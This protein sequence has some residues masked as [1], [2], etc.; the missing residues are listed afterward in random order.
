LDLRLSYTECS[1]LDNRRNKGVK[2]LPVFGISIGYICSN[3]RSAKP[4]SFRLQPEFSEPVV[5]RALPREIRSKLL[6]M[7]LLFRSILN[8]QFTPLQ[9]V[10]WSLRIA[11][12]LFLF[13]TCPHPTFLFKCRKGYYQNSFVPF[14]LNFFVV[15]GWLLQSKERKIRQNSCFR[16]IYTNLVRSS[17]VLL[18][19][20]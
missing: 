19:S 18:F 15:P 14:S 13:F 6:P 10:V 1:Q 17:I 4:I 11:K 8:L 5:I 16:L 9:I 12:F 7:L 20:T 2:I 3:R